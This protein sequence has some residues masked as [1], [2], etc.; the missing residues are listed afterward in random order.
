MLDMVLLAAPFVLYG[1]AL[2]AITAAAR[3]GNFNDD[4]EYFLG[5][6]NFGYFTALVSVLATEVSV[7]TMMIFPASGLK[8]GFVLVWLGCGYIAGRYIVARFYLGNIYKYHRLSI[9]E[10][11]TDKNPAARKILS[12][13]YLTAKYISL[14]VRFFMGAYAMNQLFGWTI[15]GWIVLMV[16]SLKGESKQSLQGDLI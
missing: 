4:K 10:T 2:L 7:A 8:N 14:G 5:G 6:R 12:F 9:Y 3:T 15:I 16:W 11:V 1:C 13:A